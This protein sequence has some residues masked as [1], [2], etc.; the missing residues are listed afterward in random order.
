MGAAKGPGTK[1]AGREASYPGGRGD[2]EVGSSLCRRE[3]SR[4]WP[5]LSPSLPSPG[6]SWLSGP[7][8]QRVRGRPLRC[9]LC[10][11]ALILNADALR[12]HLE[13][14]AHIKALAKHP[15]VQDPAGPIAVSDL[16]LEERKGDDEGETHQERLERIRREAE[17]RGAQG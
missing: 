9:R 5:S 10:P 6:R 7:K 4:R 14:K 15:E 11:R 12:Q 8:E 3:G 17:V 16:V 13:S 2:Q 1:D